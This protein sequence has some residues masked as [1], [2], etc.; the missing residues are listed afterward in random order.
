MENTPCSEFIAIPFPDL[1]STTFDSRAFTSLASS[2]IEDAEAAPPDISPLTRMPSFTVGNDG[3]M[4]AFL[5]GIMGDNTMPPNF[6]DDDYYLLGRQVV[7]PYDPMLIA[8]MEIKTRTCL[9][10][11]CRY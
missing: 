2:I 7:C 11:S 9:A 6:M 4:E 1:A 8:W 5:S 3:D 10:Q